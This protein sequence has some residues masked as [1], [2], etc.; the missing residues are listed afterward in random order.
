MANTKTKKGLRTIVS[1]VDKIYETG[2]KVTDGFKKK[3]R[4]RF[5]ELL[6]QWNYRAVPQS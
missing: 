6:P 3:M 4:I 2:K 1:V 5:D